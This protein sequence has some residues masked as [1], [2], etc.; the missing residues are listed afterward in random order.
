M[1]IGRNQKT[2]IKIKMEIIL[3]T[4]ASKRN[5]QVIKNWKLFVCHDVGGEK[6]C[7]TVDLRI[8][9]KKF[10][11]D[12]STLIKTVWICPTLCDIHGLLGC[13][14][15]GNNWWVTSACLL[16]ASF[17]WLNS[18]LLWPVLLQAALQELEELKQIVPKESLVYFLIGKVRKKTRK[19]KLRFWIYHSF[20]STVFLRP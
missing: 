10:V 14:A 2:W 20:L 9:N 5:I 18:R 6:I 11:K 13:K 7:K 8:M 19:W 4:P 16:S 3:S 15:I 17:I 1:T 12:G